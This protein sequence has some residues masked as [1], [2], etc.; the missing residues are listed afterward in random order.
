MSGMTNRVR[1]GVLSTAKIGV[2]KVIP[3]M[4][5]GEWCE[6]SAIAS[7]DPGKAEGVARDLGIAKAYGSYEELLADPQIEAIYNP[8]P[9]QLHV[10]WTIKAA[11][12]GKHV[13]CEKPLSMTV[14]EARTLLAVQERT[15]MKIG[16]AFMVRTHPQWLRA[17]ELVKSGRI[18]PLR[19]VVGFFSYY[20]VN[21]ANIRNIPECGGGA[22]MD[23]GCA[24]VVKSQSRPILHPRSRPAPHRRGRAAPRGYTSPPH[25]YA[26]R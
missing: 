12:A 8:L 16:E 25:G 11:E 6:V 7:R 26:P 4:Q 17:R 14:A 13:L 5:K 21:P 18:G 19:S 1:W 20:N 10:P 24:G 15:K 2:T 9:N 22:L 3:G 23:V